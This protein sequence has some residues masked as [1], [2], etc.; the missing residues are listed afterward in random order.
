M[1]SYTFYIGSKNNSQHIEENNSK[2]IYEDTIDTGNINKK[3]Y[4]DDNTNNINNNNNNN[5]YSKIYK[6]KI[7][8]T[9][10]RL[11]SYYA[12]NSSRQ[13]ERVEHE[14][15][16]DV[17][18]YNSTRNDNS[19][20][21]IKNKSKTPLSNEKTQNII[22]N[23]EQKII[24]ENLISSSNFSFEK[25]I[26]NSNSMS[27]L[28]LRHEVVEEDWGN[29][30]LN[31]ISYYNN[32]QNQ[33]SVNNYFE[34][35]HLKEMDRINSMKHDKFLKEYSEIRKIP[36]INENSKKIVEEKIMRYDKN[37]FDRLTDRAQVN[38]T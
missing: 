7:S 5:S 24:P 32:N 17:L 21:S 13:A 23:N 25:F 4:K 6:N 28:A 9:N 35:R 33:S 36:E 20:R 26:K 15:E 8:T 3:I 29:K 18:I 22:K 14:N 12:E 38:I 27:S 19:Q 37:V 11:D 2:F 16:N 31:D 10:S 34:R 30:K 1:S